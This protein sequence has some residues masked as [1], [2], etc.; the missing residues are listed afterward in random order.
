MDQTVTL[1]RATE[2]VAMLANNWPNY[3]FPPHAPETYQLGLTGLEWGEVQLAVAL[4]I[5]TLTWCPVPGELRKLVGEVRHH[6]PGVYEPPPTPL[7][8]RVRRLLRWHAN[9]VLSAPQLVDQLIRVGALPH[10]TRHSV[11]DTGVPLVLE[12]TTGRFTP[13]EEVLQPWLSRTVA[14][15]PQSGGN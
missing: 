2:V 15:P 5:Q 10:E 12:Q 13:L 9:G 8:E 1:P 6:Q 4:A 3:P 7:E 14:L 11:S